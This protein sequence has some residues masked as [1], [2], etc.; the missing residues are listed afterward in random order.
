MTTKPDEAA[1]T[2]GAKTTEE[3]I[4]NTPASAGSEPEPSI[5]AE[6]ICRVN[7]SHA[8]PLTSLAYMFLHIRINAAAF[9]HFVQFNPPAFLT[10]HLLIPLDP[11]YYYYPAFSISTLSSH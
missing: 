1:T 9:S 2:E 10:H 3:S 5:S 8:S 7:M 11:L 6:A 4:V